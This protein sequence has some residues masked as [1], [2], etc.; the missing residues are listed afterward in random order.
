[1]YADKLWI[2]RFKNNLFIKL[3]KMGYNTKQTFPNLK[4]KTNQT[5]Y[6]K[7]KDN[8]INLKFKRYDPTSGLTIFT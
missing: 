2:N 1:M 4:I 6:N 3:D 7:G 5:N 8:S